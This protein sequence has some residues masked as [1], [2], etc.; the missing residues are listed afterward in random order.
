MKRISI[1]L[2]ILLFGTVAS[3]SLSDQGAPELTE[4]PDTFCLKCFDD[5]IVTIV[6]R[7]KRDHVKIDSISRI[8]RG[9]TRKM[10]ENNLAIGFI[11]RNC[12]T[13]E[14]A[15]KLESSPAFAPVLAPIMQK[16]TAKRV[17]QIETIKKK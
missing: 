3:T 13:H 9:N 17:Y 10:V 7:V 4:T 5:S 11:L 6:N 14:A 15:E 1:T 8:V 2:L 16:D 12:N